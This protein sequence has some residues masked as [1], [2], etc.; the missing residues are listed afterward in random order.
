MAQRKATKITLTSEDIKKLQ[1]K[2]LYLPSATASSSLDYRL[3]ASSSTTTTNAYF[4]SYVQ[5][6]IRAD[7][8]KKFMEELEMDDVLLKHKA[9]HII[10]VTFG[11][12]YHKEKHLHIPEVHPDGWVEFHC[13]SAAEFSILKQ[14]FLGMTFSRLYAKSSFV[15]D[16]ELYPKGCVRVITVK[17]LLDPISLTD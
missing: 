8:F 17:D 5:E 7:E 15:P 4:D 12:I 11:Q 6:A 9:L 10:Y 14:R 1:M 16:M 3:T 2:G 13:S